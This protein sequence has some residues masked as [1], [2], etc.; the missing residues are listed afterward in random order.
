MK[1][2][3]LIDNHDSFVFNIYHMLKKITKE[4]VDIYPNEKIPF[5]RLHDYNKIVIS[6]GPGIPEEAGALMELLEKA[7]KT[8]AI[9]GICLGLQAIAIHFGAH[10][11]NLSKPLHGHS[12][13]LTVLN[14]KDPLT[15][16]LNTNIL[17]NNDIKVGLYHSWAVE[18]KSLPSCLQ[19]G[20]V[21]EHDNIMS[22]FHNTLPIYG[23]QFHP[24][25]IMTPFGDI[26]IS[27][28]LKINPY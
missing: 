18:K 25:S 9:L 26:I 20:S 16:L 17:D 13:T 10:L 7:E 11:F 2:I 23:I 24:E 19:I 28:W 6:P 22:L 27:E 12:S 3:L 4:S 15:K 5:N 14:K 1:K 8:H 21:N